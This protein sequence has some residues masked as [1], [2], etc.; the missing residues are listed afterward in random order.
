MKYYKDVNNNVNAYESDGSQDEFIPVQLILITDEE[1]FELANPPKTKEELSQ[2]IISKRNN[3][4]SQSDWT[5]LPDVPLEIQTK[6]KEYRQALRDIT[7]QKGYPTKVK[8][9]ELKA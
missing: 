1:A 7:N 9:P 2:E 5:Q 3:L 8:F 4:L 6:Y